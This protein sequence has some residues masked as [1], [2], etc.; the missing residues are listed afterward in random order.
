MPN[1]PDMRWLVLVLDV[2]T[3]IIASCCRLASAFKALPIRA[4]EELKVEFFKLLHL[5]CLY[6]KGERHSA[7]GVYK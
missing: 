1:K 3:C 2:R 7:R 6:A 5:L 4:E